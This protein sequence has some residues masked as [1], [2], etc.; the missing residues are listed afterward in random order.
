M[1]INSILGLAVGFGLVFLAMVL[2]G[3][4]GAF[5]DT[6]SILIVLL[7]TFAITAVSFDFRTLAGALPVLFRTVTKQ[8]QDPAAA[9][10]LL[11]KIAEKSRRDG[12]LALEN[13]LP[14]FRDQPFLHRAL[15][16]VVDGVPGDD[17]ESLLQTEVSA[18]RSRHVQSADIFRKAAEVAPAM[19]LIGTLIGLVQMLGTLDDPSSIG[20]AMAVALLTTFYGVALANMCLTPLSS[21]MNLNSQKEALLNTLYTTAATSIS[22]QENPRRLQ[23]LL[24][25]SLPPDQRLRQYK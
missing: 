16:L 9:G 10:K 25:T 7:G 14:N 20:P 21:K 1:D 6:P 2:G 12:V 11:L 18:M 22:R 5:V 8:P 3:N 19:G 4:P 24:N 23:M 17:L 15:S 13:L